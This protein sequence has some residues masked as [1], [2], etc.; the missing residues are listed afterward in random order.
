MSL[1]ASNAPFWI[2]AL[3]GSAA[4]S[5]TVAPAPGLQLFSQGID[6]SLVP[7]T[8]ICRSSPLD[9]QRFVMYPP[10][11]FVSRS[12]QPF[13]RFT[14]MNL[15]PSSP[16]PVISLGPLHL[17]PCRLAQSFTASS[18]ANRLQN[19]LNHVIRHY[20]MNNPSPSNAACVRSISC[21]G[22]YGQLLS[23]S[24]AQPPF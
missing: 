1:R 2:L 12:N 14:Y 20:G 22:S 16:C 17:A 6:R 11:A 23:R 9:V 15:A 13:A 19:V 18:S 4:L 5:Q 21:S 8:L 10:G 24:P 3:I 7:Q